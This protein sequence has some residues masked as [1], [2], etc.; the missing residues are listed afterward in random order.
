MP[1]PDDTG[2]V[3]PVEP[4]LLEKAMV[5]ERPVARPRSL[6]IHGEAKSRERS[7]TTP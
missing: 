7:A 2:S 3:Q 5:Q 6:A 1:T 4:S